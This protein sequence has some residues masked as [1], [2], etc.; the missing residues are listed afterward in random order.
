MKLYQPQHGSLTGHEHTRPVYVADRLTDLRG[1]ASGVVTLPISLDWSP[2]NEY[3]L[4]AHGA[5]ARCTPPCSAKP[6]PRT[7][8][9]GL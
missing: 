3:A 8:S 9:T 2:A 1:P 6:R 5:C 7:T 4:A